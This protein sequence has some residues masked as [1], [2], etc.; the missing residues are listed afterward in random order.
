M[1]RERGDLLV[2]HRGGGHAV[3]WNFSGHAPLRI[4]SARGLEGFLGQPIGGVRK[5]PG[6]MQG[7]SASHKY[8]ERAPKLYWRWPSIA[9]GAMDLAMRRKSCRVVV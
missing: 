6:A 5:G 3:V 1:I 4:Y 2:G 9:C 7:V 8:S